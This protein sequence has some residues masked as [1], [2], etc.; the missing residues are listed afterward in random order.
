MVAT[1]KLQCTNAASTL[2]LELRQRIPA[3]EVLNALGIIS[4]QY[5]LRDDCEVEFPFHLNT[6]KFA[7]YVPKQLV[8]IEGRWVEPLLDGSTLDVQ[9]SFFK[10]T[11]VHSTEAA[12]VETN[13]LHPVPVEDERTFSNLT[14]MKNRL[15]NRLTMHLD[16]CV[17][18][19]SHKFYT[20]ENFPYDE[21]ITPWKAKKVRYGIDA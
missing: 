5:W 2:I 8:G 20:L 19:F 16:L 1:V 11:P 9:A 15:R 10:L 13:D 17:R 18:M 12:L 6:L 4:R 7:F 21:A 14:F 3:H